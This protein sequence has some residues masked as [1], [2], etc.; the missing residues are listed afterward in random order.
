MTPQE[1][2]TH[3]RKGELLSKTIFLGE[4]PFWSEEAVQEMARKLFTQGDEVFGKIV[5]SAQ[6]ADP[7]DL[8][9]EIGTPAFFGGGR[10]IVVKDIEKASSGVEE[11]ILKGIDQLPEGSYLVMQGEKLDKRRAFAKTLLEKCTVVDSPP[12]KPFQAQEWV[13]NEARRQG[14]ELDAR[15]ARLLVERKGTM[16]GLLREELAKAAL[17]LNGASKM[18]VEEWET[19][20]GGSTETDIFG[21]LDGI[22][23]GQTC[24]ALTQLEQLLR[25][26]EPEMR[27]LYMMGKQFHQLVWAAELQRTGGNAKM[28]QQELGCHPFVAEKTW[29]QAKAFNISRLIDAVERVARGEQYIKTGR[30]EPKWELEMTVVDLTKGFRI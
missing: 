23:L 27:I 19:L 30:T 10:L 5:R 29:D 7:Q 11:A 16:P 3:T 26:G 25:M 4:E 24:K 12:F 6:S 21:L 17:Y 14:I 1:F 22:A 20:I 9:A 28:L 15:I 2:L 13:M 8:L 18:S